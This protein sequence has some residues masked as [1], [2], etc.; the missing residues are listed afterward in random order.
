MNIKKNLNEIA[1]D[2]TKVLKEQLN[3]VLDN[4]FMDRHEIFNEIKNSIVEVSKGG[5]RLRGAFVIKSYEMYGGEINDDIIK[6]AAYVEALHAQILIADDVIDQD[7]SR[8]NVET[9]HHRFKKY[10]QD[11]YNKKDPAH[12]GNSMAICASLIELY[13]AQIM[14][15]KIDMDKELLSKSLIELNKQMLLVGYGEI[16]DVV[17]ESEDEVRIEDVDLVNYLKTSS[18]TYE[19]PLHFGANLAGAQDEELKKLSEYAVPAGKAF[20]I[21]DDIL[22]MFGDEDKIGKP[23]DSDLKEGKMNILTIKT[24]ELA[25]KNAKVEFERL[26]GNQDIDDQEMDKA[27][28]IIKES[29]ALDFAQNEAIRL[30]KEAKEALDK[31]NTKGEGKDF[32]EGIADYMINREV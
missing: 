5:K 20:Q 11:K 24:L 31:L 25:N 3:E 19:A 18:Y 6:A 26:L 2:I 30:V 7:P 9:I 29:G 15:N 27:R 28:G 4:G 10:H 21:Q 12:F 13:G 14:I 1:V 32:L 22:G 8:R 23:A 17:V 16:L